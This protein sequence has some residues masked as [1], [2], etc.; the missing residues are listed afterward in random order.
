MQQSD[1][2][3]GNGVMAIATFQRLTRVDNARYEKP[4]VRRRGPTRH[5]RLVERPA[6]G[7][8]QRLLRRNGATGDQVGTGGPSRIM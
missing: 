1:V 6:L 7:Q 2:D 4:G 5:S 8:C 3:K